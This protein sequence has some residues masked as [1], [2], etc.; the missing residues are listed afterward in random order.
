MVG[1]FGAQRTFDCHTPTALSVAGNI[2][3][4]TR[5]SLRLSSPSVLAN[6]SLSFSLLV[7][8][9]VLVVVSYEVWPEDH[10]VYLFLYRLTRP[11]SHYSAIPPGQHDLYFEWRPYYIDYNLL[12]RELK[13]H[14]LSH[15][16]VQ[17]PRLTA[18]LQER[19]TAH[20]WSDKDERQFTQLLEKELDKIHDFQKAKVRT[21]SNCSTS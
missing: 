14:N 17:C 13:V 4:H 3:A 12:K 5:A 2:T 9:W 11:R 21:V 6:F 8:S 16:A 15:P 19:T 20:A 18:A 1:L 10:C 7:A